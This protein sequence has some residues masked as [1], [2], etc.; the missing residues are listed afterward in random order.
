VAT[1]DVPLRVSQIASQNEVFP[2]RNF[3]PTKG[4]LTDLASAVAGMADAGI[5][6]R[7][8]TISFVMRTLLMILFY[9]SLSMLYGCICLTQRLA[10]AYAP[11]RQKH[12]EPDET[13]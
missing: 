7:E 6:E 12:H 5:N 9:G 4:Y 11:L 8:R 13:V 3:F 1:C 2:R 10:K